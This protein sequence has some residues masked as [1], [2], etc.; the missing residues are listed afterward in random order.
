MKERDIAFSI[1]AGRVAIG[2]GLLAVPALAGSG[3]VGRAAGAPAT[4]LFVRATGARDVGIGLGV[5]SAL[6]G[7]RRDLRPWL[8]ASLIADAADA[9]ATL[10]ARSELPPVAA[11][12]AV[13]VAGGSAV[14]DAVLLA[15]LD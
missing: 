3:W 4:Q 6:R 7:K 12:N 10:L 14:I 1:A 15:R 2:A 8:L 9:V 11:A 13:A 5:I